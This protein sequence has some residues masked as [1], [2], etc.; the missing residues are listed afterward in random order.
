MKKIIQLFLLA[1]LLSAPFS[2]PVRAQADE[3]ARRLAEG[4]GQMLVELLQPERLEVRVSDGRNF[5]WA[6]AYGGKMD[7]I[8]VESMKLRAMLS[9]NLPANVDKSDKYAMA[10]IIL[11]SQGEMVLLEKDVNTLFASGLDTKG[12]SNLAF[13]FRPQGFKAEGIFSTQLVVPLRI[14]LRAEGVLGLQPDGVYLEDTTF[15]V[16][17]VTMPESMVK[18]M[19][20]DKV[21][22]LLSF[23]EIPFPI[24]FKTIAMTDEAVILSGAPQPFEAGA[25]WRYKK[26]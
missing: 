4:I 13:D 8:R 6:E 5:A 14:R 21:N 2:P 15:F 19:V 12:F 1:L 17:G 20:L 10:K 23:Q 11:M 18:S 3:P 22:P 9:E 25:V 26:P 24:E 16:E 7:K